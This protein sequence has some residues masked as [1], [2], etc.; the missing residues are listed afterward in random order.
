[1]YQMTVLTQLKKQ[2]KDKKYEIAS[3]RL[4]MRVMQNSHY[5]TL[6]LKRQEK[7]ENELSDLITE[8]KEKRI[9]SARR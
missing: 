5:F 4:K 3:N 6:I 7:L 1:M 9:K 8:Y 2:I